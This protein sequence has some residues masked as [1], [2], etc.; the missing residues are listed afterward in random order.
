MICLICRQA[1]FVDG[2]TSVTLQRGEIRLVINNVPARSCPRCGDAVVEE[3][4]AVRLLKTAE[5]VAAMGMREYV[6]EYE[7]ILN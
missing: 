4:V 3:D 1:E 7:K 6:F 2:F 5:G